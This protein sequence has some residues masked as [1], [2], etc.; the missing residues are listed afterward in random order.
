M[1]PTRMTRGFTASELGAGLHKLGPSF[2][3]SSFCGVLGRK[4]PVAR[5][6]FV[7]RAFRSH[8]PSVG[9]LSV[10]ACMVDAF[11]SSA[12]CNKRRNMVQ[13]ADSQA[14]VAGSTC[15]AKG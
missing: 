2:S 5:H 3:L 10:F 13:I 4:R 1:V 11:L 9:R 7:R 12:S 6:L 8:L 14:C 15:L